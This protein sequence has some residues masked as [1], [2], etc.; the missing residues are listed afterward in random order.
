MI[1]QQ[2]PITIKIN[3]A[4]GGG[5]KKKRKELN[6]TQEAI[7]KHLGISRPNLVNI[8]NGV[9]GTTPIM[10]WLICNVLHCTPNDLFPAQKP[11]KHK[12]KKVSKVVVVRTKVAV[13]KIYL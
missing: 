5:I 11:T 9:T 6:I 4:I 10:L 3:K 13:D 2:D 1:K 12:I 8:E 7:T